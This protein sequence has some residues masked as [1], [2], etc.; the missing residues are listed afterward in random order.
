MRSS[1]LEAVG[2]N[3]LLLTVGVAATGWLLTVGGAATGW[4]IVGN[5]RC[6]CHDH[7]LAV[8]WRRGCHWLLTVGGAATGWLLTVG[9][10]ATGWLLLAVEVTGTGFKED[11]ER[12]IPNS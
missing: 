4:L 9:G 8:N 6:G 10:A 7:W 5:S 12:W 1:L 11:V 3:C 2:D